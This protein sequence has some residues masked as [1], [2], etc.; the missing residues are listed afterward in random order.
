MRLPCEKIRLILF[1]RCY[2]KKPYLCGHHTLYKTE[3]PFQREFDVRNREKIWKKDRDFVAA[4]FEKYSAYLEKKSLFLKK[5]L[6]LQK[7]YLSLP[8]FF[9]EEI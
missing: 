3:K 7:I 2:E 9:I 1:L 5:Y 4:S 8:R 6:H